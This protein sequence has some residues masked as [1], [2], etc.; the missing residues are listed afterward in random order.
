MRRQV[1]LLVALITTA[2]VASFVL[3]LLMLVGTLARDRG[4]AATRQEADSVAV[5]V[6][7][8]HDDPQFADALRADLVGSWSGSSVVLVD[9]SVVGAPWAAVASDPEY[10]QARRGEA[11]SVLDPAGGRVYVPVLLEGG[12]AVVR[13]AITPDELAEGVARARVSIVLLG[14]CLSGLAVLVAAR[15]GRAVSSPLLDVAATAHRLREGDLAARAPL[16]GPPETVELAAALN[17]LADRIGQLLAAERESV[18]GLAHRLRTPVTAVR[19][20]AERVG[21]PRTA[22]DLAEL[23]GQLQIAIDEVVRDARRPLREDLPGGCDATAVVAA[24][25]DFWRPL[26]EDE[27]R[28]VEVVLPQSAAPV[29]LTA[30]DLGDVVDICIDNVFAHTAVG[31]GF[32]VCLDVA[33]SRA[34]VTVADRGPGFP[35]RRPI[36]RPG[37]SGLGLELARRTVEKAHGVFGTSAPGDPQGEVWFEVPL[38]NDR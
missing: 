28:A 18:R 14:L 1:S 37:T 33:G 36:P 17:G 35:V 4:M 16:A 7:S 21:D 29:A 6:S 24:R 12:V 9:G 32:R 19:L 25:I 3:P 11:F 5:L 27:G 13:T 38:G 31:V 2:I 10:L 15:V 23:V 26:A 34:R 30:L 22:A 8:L 20:Q